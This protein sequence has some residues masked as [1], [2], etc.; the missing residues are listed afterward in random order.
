ME[1]FPA[2]GSS[3]SPIIKGITEPPRSLEAEF[4]GNMRGLQGHLNSCYLDA[5]LYSMFAFSWVFDT[6][7]HR[8]RRETDLP[9][10]EE[11]QSVLRE[12]IV[13]PLRVH[14]F[15]RADRVLH[16]RELL[17]KLSTTA[18]LINEEK[19]PEEFLNSLL[20]Q[21]LKAD[22]FLHLKSRDLSMKDSEGAYFYEIITEKDDSVKIAQLQNVLEESFFSA[23]IILAEVPSCLILQMPWFG[24]RYKMYDM[25]LPN[26]ELDV[27]YIVE[28]VPRVCNM[29]GLKVAQYECKGCLLTGM[30]KDEDNGIMS[31]CSECH[32]QIHTNPKR[33]DHKYRP[34]LVPRQQIKQTEE[35]QFLPEKQKMEL[36]AVVCIETSH[37]V[38]FVKCGTR[39]E[40]PWCFFDSMAHRNGEKNGYNIPAVTPCPEAV[41]WLSKD[42][43]EILAAKERGEVPGKVRRLLGDGYLCMYQNLDMAMY[44]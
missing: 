23:D 18:G 8:K 1:D 26:L 27:S 44:K 41:E 40:S 25:I 21:V 4:C 32:N 16:L 10:Y 36:F 17:D 2:F 28:S 35:I 38:A 33:R 13:N 39:P 37:Y 19:D 34:I 11:V 14:G 7:L 5:T 6:I 24:S 9:E 3:P 30:V 42:R 12:A 43:K 15:V 29:C 22:P 20:K 31:F